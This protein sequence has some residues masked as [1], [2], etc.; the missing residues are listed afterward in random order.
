MI[1]K[2][3]IRLALVSAA[4]AGFAFGGHA[5]A[6]GD[7]P[8]IE[9]RK[10]SFSG[11]GGHFDQNQ[12]QRGFQ[13]YK[14]VCATCH[15]LSRL[16]FRNL[17]QKGGPEFPEDRVKAMAEAW[18][19]QIPDMTE[20]GETAVV[21]RDKDRKVTGFSYVTRAPRLSDRIPGPYKNEA[22]ARSIHGGANPPDLSLIAKG[23]STEYHGS[24]AYH[25]ISML[26]DIATGYQEG[27][28]NYLYAL[29]TS[30]QDKAPAYRL[31]GAKLV[32]VAEKDIKDPKA[33]MRCA[34]ITKGEPGKPD[35][36]NVMSDVMNYNTAF[37]GSQIAMAQPLRDKQVPYSDGTPPT[38]SNYA[39]DVS[40][41][42]SWAADPSHDE[43]K[44]MGWQV[45]LYLLVTSVLLY[46]AKK[47]I[48]RDVH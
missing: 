24:V 31:D 27:G 20:A 16:S 35:T 14:E 13:V 5:M 37:A 32:V 10:W 43:R 45:M 11:P 6:A 19:T 30:Y 46:V 42:L 23:R 8:Q 47:R 22:E 1:A 26:K 15:G 21:K 48:W 44:R 29:L 3:N 34:S 41:F 2:M 12:L 25:P 18:P 33:V 4:L 9:H 40:A 28:A 7:G 39:A 38:L 17:A 36:C